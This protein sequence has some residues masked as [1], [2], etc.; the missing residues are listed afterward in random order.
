MRRLCSGAPVRGLHAPLALWQA[1]LL[2][3]DGD[4]AGCSS[5]APGPARPLRVRV[6]RTT[7]SPV[8][9]AKLREAEA[10]RAAPSHREPF[11]T[12]Q[13]GGDDRRLRFP[14]S[15][16]PAASAFERRAP[17][18][19]AV[20]SRQSRQNPRGTRQFAHVALDRWGQEALSGAVT[21]KAPLHRRLAEN[22][23]GHFRCARGLSVFPASS[24]V[25]PVHFGQCGVAV[26]GQRIGSKE[27][28]VGFGD[29]A[30]AFEILKQRIQ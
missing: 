17:G 3:G 29:Q 23:F 27:T 2:H 4:R 30:L 26:V 28:V 16:C 24:A 12:W 15:P 21:L 14:A 7:N 10:C 9:E 5:L 19:K 1:T 22:H 13:R 11:E 25:A 6:R 8:F 18:H 20:P